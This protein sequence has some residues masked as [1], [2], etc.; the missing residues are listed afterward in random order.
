MAC[1][2]DKYTLD[3]CPLDEYGIVDPFRKLIVK[4]VKS[5]LKEGKWFTFCKKAS[6]E[7]VDLMSIENKA[8]VKMGKIIGE[9]FYPDTEYRTAIYKHFLRSYMCYYEVPAVKKGYGSNSNVYQSSFEKDIITSNMAVIAAWLDMTVEEVAER[10]MVYLDNAYLDDGENDF[11]YV[12]LVL[13]KD[14]KRSIRK[15]RSSLDLSKQGTRVVPMF[16]LKEGIDY[17]YN[18]S[19]DSVVRVSFV[20]DGG[21]K[22][23]IDFSF[24]RN[25]VRDIYGESN[26][27]FRGFDACYEGDLL[28]DKDI[29]RGYLKVIE[30]GGSKYDTPTRSVNFS[31]VCSFEVGVTPDL[32]FINIDMDS[33]LDSFKNDLGVSFKKSQ[34]IAKTLVEFDL[35]STA[36]L[37]HI[38]S[39]IELESWVERKKSLFGTVFLRSLALFMLGNPMDFPNYTGSPVEYSHVS[40]SFGVSSESVDDEG[41]AVYSD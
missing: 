15:P 2:I 9:K 18:K 27:F 8:G 7:Q 5:T 38:N 39:S 3:D 30:I 14:G 4:A 29:L 20:K 37:E 17:L 23:D 40:D 1:D 21:E 16:A 35:M 19:L 25:I 12:K 24:N 33:I 6:P 28:E 11:P 22:R 36:E 26:Y 10:Y 31:R 13:S 41:M 32:T 34:R